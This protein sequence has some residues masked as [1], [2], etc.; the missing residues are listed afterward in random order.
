MFISLYIIKH[1]RTLSYVYININIYT[2][3]I[4]L[5]LLFLYDMIYICYHLNIILAFNS[6]V[7]YYNI[8]PVLTIL[9][10]LFFNRGPLKSIKFVTKTWEINFIFTSVESPVKELA[11]IPT[12]PTHHT[13][14]FH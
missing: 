12:V 9:C 5:L 13:E 1:C 4:F 8:I 14:G 6:P 10:W 11:D 2:N 3:K 7:L